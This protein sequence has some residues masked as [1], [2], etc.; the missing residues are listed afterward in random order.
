[1]TGILGEWLYKLVS[2]LRIREREAN[3]VVVDWLPLA[4]QLYTDAV[5]NT[6]TVGHSIARM[7]DWLQVTGDGR[8]SSFLSSILNSLKKY[9]LKK[10]EKKRKKYRLDSVTVNFRCLIKI[11]GIDIVTELCMA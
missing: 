5:N 3:V 1:M 9:R 2:A 10:K 8:G 4:H 6:K 11:F 7:L